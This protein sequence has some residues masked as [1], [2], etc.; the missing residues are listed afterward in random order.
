MDQISLIRFRNLLDRLLKYCDNVKSEEEKAIL[1]R[2]GVVALNK[3]RLH[4]DVNPMIGYDVR[5]LTKRVDSCTDRVDFLDLWND[6]ID[7]M[8]SCRETLA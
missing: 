8:E 5:E 1:L 6:T 7:L 3:L 4:A 2:I